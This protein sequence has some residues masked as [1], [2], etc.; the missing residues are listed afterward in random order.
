MCI[1]SFNQI[2]FSFI[3]DRVRLSSNEKS[4]QLHTHMVHAL[5]RYL[6]LESLDELSSYGIDSI[7]GL[8]DL[9]SRV[10]VTHSRL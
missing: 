8:V 2:L 9:V 5:V 7:A 4:S 6:G 10:S 1:I 3:A